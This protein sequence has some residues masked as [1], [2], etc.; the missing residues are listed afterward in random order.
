[1]SRGKN[2]P[3]RELPLSNNFIFGEV[4]SN[5]EVCT[6]FLEALLG[7]PI[8][9][10][11]YINTEQT[12][13]DTFGMHGIR[14]DVYIEDENNSRYDIEMQC[15]DYKALERRIRYYQ[16]GIDRNFLR[17]GGDYIDLPESYIIFICD[18]DYYKAGL[19]LYERESTLKGTGIQYDDGSHAIIL[20]TKYSKPGDASK[21][22]LEFLDYIRTNDGNV[23]V[24]GQLTKLAR[25][26]CDEVRSD[27]K[28][29]EKYMTLQRLLQDERREAKVETLVELYQSGD[30]PLDK[31]AAKC[32]LSEKEF[33]ELTKNSK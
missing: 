18:F 8:A 12:Y 23:Q 4:M 30:I 24:T 7:K 2:I 27:E 22:I 26:L 32:G 17:A 11:E 1:M 16:G 28:K 9:K 15:V 19:A 31:A 13:T 25:E 3:Y 5:A 6:L 29:E 10:I 33:L 20:N 21:D 14:L